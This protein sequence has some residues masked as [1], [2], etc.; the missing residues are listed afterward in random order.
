[1]RNFAPFLL[2]I[3]G[4]AVLLRVDF[5]FTVAYFLVGIYL[6]VRVWNRRAA[7]H[8]RVQREFVNR[9]FTGDRV[10][11]SYSIHNEGWLPVPWL[12]DRKSVV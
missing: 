9:A 3:F 5:F 8:L 1:M 12:E 11:V 4:V 6:L 2:L 7:E 10:P